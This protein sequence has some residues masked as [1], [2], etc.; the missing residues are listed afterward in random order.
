MP[1]NNSS[2]MHACMR[3]NVYVCVCVCVYVCV[4]VCGRGGIL[5]APMPVCMNPPHYLHPCPAILPPM[6]A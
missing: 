5:S 2:C 1:V 4:C 3:V 6:S